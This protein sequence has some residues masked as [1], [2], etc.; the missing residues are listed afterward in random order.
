MSA[1]QRVYPG[2]HSCSL[3]LSI[4][5][6]RRANMVF[7]RRSQCDSG[8]IVATLSMHELCYTIGAIMQ[9]AGDIAAADLNKRLSICVPLCAM[10]FKEQ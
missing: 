1:M 3:S 9:S 2:L 8:R 10:K 5:Y 7:D 6:P 4:R